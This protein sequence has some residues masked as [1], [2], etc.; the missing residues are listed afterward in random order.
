M[1]AAGLWQTRDINDKA[2]N[3]FFWE[4]C[5]RGPIRCPAPVC[6]DSK[7]ILGLV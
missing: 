1:K 3:F 7:L 6:N 4:P 2:D 5:A